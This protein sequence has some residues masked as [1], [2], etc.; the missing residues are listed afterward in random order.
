MLATT[1]ELGYQKPTAGERPTD[2]LELVFAG[3]DV[4]GYISSN[5]RQQA[6]AAIQQ[7]KRDVAVA[8]QSYLGPSRAEEVELEDRRM[9]AWQRAAAVQERRDRKKRKRTCLVM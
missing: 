2:Y 5:D 7:W 6:L 3:P 4:E 9:V 1:N 8:K